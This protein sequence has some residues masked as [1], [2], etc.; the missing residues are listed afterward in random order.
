MTDFVKELLRGAETMFGEV[1]NEVE[2]YNRPEHLVHMLFSVD[3]PNGST[4]IAAQ[5][6]C[7]TKPI[8]SKALYRYFAVWWR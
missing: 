7:F 1:L 4:S 6:A 8:V 5:F 3:S 2:P